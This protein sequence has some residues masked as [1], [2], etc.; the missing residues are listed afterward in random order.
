MAIDP[1]KPSVELS[2]EEQR[3]L[4]EFVLKMS[5]KDMNIIKHVVR[6]GKL[7]KALFKFTHNNVLQGRSFKNEEELIKLAVDEL[8]DEARFIG[9][10]TL[11]AAMSLLCIASQFS[12]PVKDQGEED[13]GTLRAGNQ[14]LEDMGIH[15]M[16][17][18]P[19]QHMSNRVLVAVL[20]AYF[21]VDHDTAHTALA[22]AVGWLANACPFT[23]WK[24]ASKPGQ[25]DHKEFKTLL[26][27]CA[28][29]AAAYNRDF[30]NKTR[31]DHVLLYGIIAEKF[32]NENK[33]FPPDTNI[34]SLDHPSHLVQGTR[35][36]NIVESLVAGIIL[37]QDLC[38]DDTP[39]DME[40]IIKIAAGGFTSYENVGSAS[41][42]IITGSYSMEDNDEEHLVDIV[43]AKGARHFKRLL[44]YKGFKFD[45]NTFPTHDKFKDDDGKYTKSVPFLGLV[46][47]KVHWSEYDYLG[48]GNTFGTRSGGFGFNV[49]SREFVEYKSYYSKEGKYDGVAVA[50]VI[51]KK[52][53]K[54]VTSDMK[55][56]DLVIVCGATYAELEA[57]AK[58]NGRQY[59]T[60]FKRHLKETVLKEIRFPGTGSHR[61]ISFCAPLPV[62]NNKAMMKKLTKKEVQDQDFHEALAVNPDALEQVKSFT[63][64]DSIIPEIFVYSASDNGKEPLALIGSINKLTELCPSTR[65]SENEGYLWYGRSDGSEVRIICSYRNKEHEA[66]N[67]KL[68]VLKTRLIPPH[69]C[70]VDYKAVK[71]AI[72]NETKVA[73]KCPTNKGKRWFIF[74]AV[75]LRREGEESEEEEEY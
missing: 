34:Y 24:K 58:Q 61:M 47:R 42:Y 53:N 28:E 11:T 25:E 7:P 64:T 15:V 4:A 30:L 68:R 38:G 13:V 6:G 31:I 8:G 54:E 35:L 5:A 41:E 26:E 18:A 2:A 57:D 14:D 49:S 37:V 50:L 63:N 27:G 16:S 32:V 72:K 9:A 36:R 56:K 69:T 43:R 45:E 65:T 66:I 62:F 46:L 23:L 52:K 12:Y 60:A 1:P 73:V 20:H 75:K 29:H 22:H 10:Q 19:T 70:W 67:D 48:K 59:T 21:G 40:K 33:V 55:M 39:L 44:R 17:T 51:P 74:T 71:T 3:E